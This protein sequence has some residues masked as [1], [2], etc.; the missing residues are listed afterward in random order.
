[1]KPR[2][3]IVEDEPS[4]SDN[5][6]YALSSEGFEPTLCATVGEAL[7]VFSAS[8]FSLVILDIGLPDG[9][10]FDL[11]RSMREKRDTPIIFLTA[12]SSEVDKVSGLELGADDYL[13]KPFSVRELVARVRAILRRTVRKAAAET[14]KASSSFVVDDE[15]F[16]ITYH[17]K[18]LA[19]SRY[20]FRLLRQLVQRPGRVY[21]REQLMSLVWE[22]PEMSLERTV[23]THVK[24]IRAKLKA[25]HPESDPIVT[26]RGIGYSIKA[27]K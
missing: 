14:A 17:G 6:R 25:A 27:E 18:P 3:L 9:N 13:T 23:D 12:R 4:I 2:I 20:E 24:T 10:G 7:E 8:P 22:E 21:T 5:I 1:M 11:A 19:L 16:L 15:Q 26:H